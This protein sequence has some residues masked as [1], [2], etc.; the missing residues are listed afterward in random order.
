MGMKSELLVELRDIFGSSVVSN[1]KQLL[2]TVLAED[3]RWAQSALELRKQKCYAVLSGSNGFL[4]VTRQLYDEYN[5]DIGEMVHNYSSDHGILFETKFDI[6]RGHIL[7]IKT[8]NLPPDN[9]D[10]EKLPE[11]FINKRKTNRFLECTTLELIKCNMRVNNVI[12]EIILVSDQIID[13]LIQN[14]LSP[15]LA[16]LFK[17]SEAVAVLDVMCSFAHLVKTSSTGYVRPLFS[18]PSK[19]NNKLGL[20][21]ARHPIL[22]RTM[23]F[24]PFI[25]ND[26]YASPDTAHMNI[27]TGGMVYIESE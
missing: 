10:G 1:V 4:D 6:K 14:Q 24:R 25:G 21:L 26:F 17:L 8:T 19:H 3:C 27:I 11:I 16:D 7:K 12:S 18:S 13:S 5:E 23:K 20:K 9:K 2:E 15:Y 22:E